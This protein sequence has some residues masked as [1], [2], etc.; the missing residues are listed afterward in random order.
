[1]K[2]YFHE[3]F[4][5]IIANNQDGDVLW[6]LALDCQEKA[7]KKDETKDALKYFKRALKFAKA[8]REQYLLVASKNPSQKEQYLQNAKLA[9]DELIN[10]FRK[11][12]RELIDES[13]SCESE[14][15]SLEI[16]T[17]CPSEQLP[18]PPELVTGVLQ[19]NSFFVSQP[20]NPLNDLYSLQGFENLDQIDFITGSPLEKIQVLLNRLSWVMRSKIIQTELPDNEVKIA[21]ANSLVNISRDCTQKLFNW[22][23]PYSLEARYDELKLEILFKARSASVAAKTIYELFY[24][25]KVKVC[26][27]QITYINQEIAKIENPSNL[28]V[29][30]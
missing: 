3:T 8:S 5:E 10:P 7:V 24:I 28:T 6:N 23:K 21:N 22:I 26:K 15:D 17:T 30:L 27:A 25:T 18:V 13:K 11:K 29:N 14:E 4:N 16:K 20:Q 2:R 1:M 19:T 12:I 9:R